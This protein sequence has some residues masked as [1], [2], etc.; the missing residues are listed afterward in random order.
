MQMPGEA[1]EIDT[2]G[3]TTEGSETLSCLLSGKP[4]IIFKVLQE[5]T[6]FL[7]TSVSPWTSF[8]SYRGTNSPSKRLVIFYN[9]Q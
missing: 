4:V 5:N 2:T 9:E 7:R 6:E 3:K 8:Q 1:P